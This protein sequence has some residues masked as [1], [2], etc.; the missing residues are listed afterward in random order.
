MTTKM[1]HSP[2]I[3]MLSSMADATNELHLRVTEALRKTSGARVAFLFGSQNHG[4]VWAESDLDVAVRW[5]AD[6]DDD[7][8]WQA[9]LALIGALTDLLGRLGERADIVD[10]DR[11]DSAVGFK[12]VRDGICVFAVS[13]AERVRAIV[14]VARRYD[15]DAPRRDLFRRAARAAVGRMQEP[16]RGRP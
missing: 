7:A 10:L 14:D 16:S 6:F 8:R 13:D 3:G 11:A 12:A 15:D 2:K 5:P 9:R 4:Q 1:A